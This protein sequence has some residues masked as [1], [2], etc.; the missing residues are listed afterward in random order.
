M[1]S[2]IL[3][4]GCNRLMPS[5]SRLCV[6]VNQGL[7][8]NCTINGTGITEWS[9]TS[10]IGCSDG[11]LLRHVR[12][13]NGTMGS[14]GQISAWSI[15]VDNGCYSSQL[16]TTATTALN[17]TLMQCIHNF[18]GK[19]NIIGTVSLTVISGENTCAHNII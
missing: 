6:C 8:F 9:G 2:D 10:I 15:G 19:R 16:T 3:F 5:E 12:F 7:T 11:L 14:C 18:E 13:R 17:S 4:P 1:I